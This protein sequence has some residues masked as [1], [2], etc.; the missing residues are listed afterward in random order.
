MVGELRGAM[1]DVDPRSGLCIV[2]DH[3]F[4]AVTNVLWLDATLVKAGLI[5]LKGQG[6]T[7]EAAGISDWVAQSWPAGGSA[8]IVLKNP[9]DVTAR[10][11][12]KTFLERLAADAENG[13]ASVLD[14]EAIKPMGG[15]PQAQF[16]IDMKPGCMISPT[17]QP[18]I[19]SVVSARGT[20]GYS[21]VHPEM[22][23]TFILSGPGI[24]ANHSLG[25]IDM[26]SIA[27]TL[28]KFMGVTFPSAEMPALE[29]LTPG[30]VA[31]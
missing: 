13:I 31:R 24:R 16:W 27:P 6:T 4:A 18:S 12:V 17:L 3:G 15:A 10:A 22:G 8:A 11:R 1:R 25:T 9:D 28:A 23:A 5:T 29:V 21:P 14:V 20:H 26:R 30:E 19:V 2:S 7:V